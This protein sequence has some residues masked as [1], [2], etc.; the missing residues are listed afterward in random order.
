MSPFIRSLDFR[1]FF[2]HLRYDNTSLR[3]KLGHGCVKLCSMDDPLELVGP[4][5][6]LKPDT[7]ALVLVKP[8]H[9]R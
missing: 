6:G 7:I 3:M 5:V 1:S 9:L 2:N 8:V 4:N